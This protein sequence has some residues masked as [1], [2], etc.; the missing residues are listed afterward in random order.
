MAPNETSAPDPALCFGSVVDAY[1]RGRPGYPIDAVRWL[2]GDEPLSVLELGSGTGK[3]TRELVA[4]GHDVH[5]TDPDPGMLD[6]L[7]RN[8]VVT[9]ISQTTA[10]EIPVPDSTFDIVVA[11]QAYHWF[12]HERALPEI[13]RVLKRGGSL[14]LVWNT[15][16]E[17]I[18]WVKRLGR[19]IGSQD[20]DAGPGDELESSPYFGPVEHET[21]KHW[22]VIDRSTIQDLVLSRSNVATL[23][24]E[25][26]AAK[27]REVLAFYDEFGRGMDGMQLPYVTHCYRAVVGIKPQSAPKTLVASGEQDAATQVGS[28]YVGEETQPVSLS[29]A[30]EL[31]EIID[32]PTDDDSGVLLIDFR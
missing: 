8:Y 2:T 12:D 22:Q 5:A 19:V 27:L 14:S 13:A 31:P 29:D 18:P 4:L 17:R 32:P 28:S 3:L 20:Q 7:A 10:E 9:R 24:A 21:F 11:A 26:R 16:D 15:R 25:A 30:A 1:E 23:P 6:V